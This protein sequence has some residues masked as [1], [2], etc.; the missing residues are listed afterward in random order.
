M[1]RQIVFDTETT[2]TSVFHDRVVEIACV[3]LKDLVPT[4][5]TFQRYINPER[6]VP[7]EVVAVHGLTAEFL[8]NHPVFAHVNVAEAFLEFVGEDSVFVAH[9]AEFDRGFLNAELSR[10]NKGP[11][12]KERFV[13]TLE[14]ARKMFPGAPA[15][16][17]AL[18]KRFSISLEERDKHGAL[19]DA[20]LLAQVY[21]EL[22]GGREQRLAL[23]ED[24]VVSAEDVA[25]AAKRKPRPTPLQ[26]PITD[27]ERA[28]HAAFVETLGAKAL[29]K[30][31]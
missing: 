31:L 1:S 27:E 30:V 19:V 14:M 6:D 20:H 18:C 12:G 29:W 4:G 10:L 24:T 8:R 2:G 5:R 16:L 22:N 25:K 17:N 28:A 21:L 9:N 15:S 26:S 11:I 7:A 13:D 3:E 23:F